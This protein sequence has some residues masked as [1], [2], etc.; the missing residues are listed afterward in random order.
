MLKEG[1]YL[2]DRYEIV[3]KAGSGGMSDVYKAKDHTLGRF[4]G[5]KVLKQE[6]SDDVNFV[7][8]F[9]TEAQSAAGLEHPNI[10]NIYDVGSENSVHY[11]VMEYV[12]GITLKTYIE[13]KGQLSFKEAVSIAIQVGRGIEAAHNKHI[14]HRDIK[15]Q[16]III[17]T[18]GKVKVTDFGIAKAA[19][20]N[21]ISSDVMGSVHYASPEQARNGFV[22]GKS[23]IYSLGIVMY[24]MV[25][26]RVP[27]DGE[28]TVAVAIQHLQE[29]MVAPSA[30]APNLPVSM[31]KIILK[32]TQKSPDRRY[33]SISD[34]LID[35]KKA[36][37]SP[38]EDFVVMV[39]LGQQDKTR[40]MK[41][42]EVES[43]KQ[44]TRN[45]YYQEEL[46][47]EDEDDDEEDDEDDEGFLNPKMEKAV[48]I[49]GIVAAVVIVAIIIYIGGSFLGLF[50][51]GGGDKADKKEPDTKTEA[52]KED[53]ENKEESEKIEMIDLRGYTFD[54]AKD[55][56][57][58]MHLGIQPNGEESSEEYPEG[59]IVSQSEEKGTMVEKNTTILV[60]I[61]SGPGEFD[62]PDVKGKAKGDAETTL[63]NAGL[64]PVFDYESSDSIP[65]DQ[66]IS[67]SPEAGEKAKKGDTVTVML[68]KGRETVRMPDVWN[69]PEAEAREEIKNLGLTVASTSS[70]YSDEIPEGNVMGQSIAPDKMV[71]QGTQVT[72]TIS[73]GRKIT[74]QYYS[75]NNYNIDLP[76]SI[77]EDA[78]RVEAKITLY[79][80]EGND[81]INSW[82]ATS[83]PFTVNASNIE[84]CSQ[85][86][87]VIDWEWTYRDEDDAE[88][89]ETD[90][91]TI[92][93]VGF[94][95]N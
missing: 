83:F 18:E 15:P 29:E 12:E 50:K 70:D 95:Q 26:G 58:Q 92:D 30:F 57:N 42:E 81:A 6:F 77:P 62:V 82:T 37:I 60:V 76:R 41:S 21:T 40:V 13:K 24:E 78:I 4:V 32:C 11:I 53:E 35:L 43:I 66:V 47:D 64:V 28:S 68:S 75:L 14:I 73:L 44:Q 10:V 45:I 16:N 65:N 88:I 71:E 54:E 39:P 1:V 7:T 25:T 90:Q 79:K 61:S 63:R 36:L 84:N 51:F 86:Y 23:D 8:K 19:T 93:G 46:N 49:M 34:L 67:Q 59:Q 87:F 3:G 94:T 27:F 74:T 72:L 2:A 38:D 20:N 55:V 56:L 22:D 33:D 17:S 9:R 69:K 80:S 89:T 31:E 52:E 91:T 85:G 5:I 48:T